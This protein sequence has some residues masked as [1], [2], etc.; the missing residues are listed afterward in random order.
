MRNPNG[1]QLLYIQHT[2][3]VRGKAFAAQIDRDKGEKRSCVIPVSQ[4]EG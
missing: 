4:R 2:L 3:I 1:D